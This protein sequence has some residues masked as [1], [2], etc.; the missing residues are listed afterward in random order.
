MFVKLTHWNGSPTWVNVDKLCCIW[1][2]EITGGSDL[3]MDWP[4]ANSSVIVL[5]TPDEVSAILHAKANPGA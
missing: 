2:H 5:E 4:I 1:P 3:D